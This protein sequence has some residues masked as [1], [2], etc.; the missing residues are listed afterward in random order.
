L[1]KNIPLDSFDGEIPEE[2]NEVYVWYVISYICCFYNFYHYRVTCIHHF[3]SQ[4][5]QMDKFHVITLFLNLLIMHCWYLVHRVQ[6]V[7]SE[8]S[9]LSWLYCKLTIKEA[10]KR[11]LKEGAQQALLYINSVLC[12]VFNYVYLFILSQ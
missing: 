12:E 11:T 4:N 10:L 5:Y 7:P 2:E 8:G 3:S 9:G 1:Q 6:L